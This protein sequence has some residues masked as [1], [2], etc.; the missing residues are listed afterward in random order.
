MRVHNLNVAS[1]EPTLPKTERAKIRAAVRELELIS[2]SASSWDDIKDNY[3]QT[4]GR[5]NL[6]KRLHP[7]EAQKYVEKIKAIE[8]HWI[9]QTE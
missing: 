9:T 6:M 8:K 2:Q 1:G 5:V 7:Y 3:E 4:K